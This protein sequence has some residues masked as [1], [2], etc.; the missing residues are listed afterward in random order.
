MFFAETEGVLLCL[1]RKPR[2]TEPAAKAAGEPKVNSPSPRFA[3]SS[4]REGAKIFTKPLF[5]FSLHERH[6]CAGVLPRRLA[7]AAPFMYNFRPSVRGVTLC[8]FP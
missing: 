6:V 4:L 8:D 5:I 3:G 1:A 2:R 7:G